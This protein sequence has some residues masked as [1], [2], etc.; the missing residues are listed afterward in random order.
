MGMKPLNEPRLQCK[1]CDKTFKKACKTI[2]HER[3]HTGERPFVCDY[4]DCDK[5]YRRSSHLLV[6][7]KAHKNIKDIICSY[8]GC[9]AS[10]RTKQHLHRHEISHV[11][12]TFKCDRPD[13]TAEFNKRNQLRWHK[14]AHLKDD[15]ECKTC[16]SKLDSLY[17]LEKHMER[18]HTNPVLH[19]CSYCGVEFQKWTELM[20]H[21]FEAHPPTCDI[22]NKVFSLKSNLKQHMAI[23]HTEIASVNCEFPGCDAVLRTKY[24]LKTHMGLKHQIG[25]SYT[26]VLC[27]KGFP[28]KSLYKKHIKKHD[29]EKKKEET[30]EEEEE[31]EAIEEEET[32]KEETEETEE[33]IGTA[34]VLTG[35]SSHQQYTKIYC[36]FELCSYTFTS[37][38]LL[39]RHLEGTVHSEEM[40]GTKT[41]SKEKCV[42]NKRARIA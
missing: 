19:K 33:K 35:R 4:P 28:F 26:C 42:I 39:R 17:A 40:K 13:C 14:A 9:G 3:T 6:H 12:A 20:A 38:Y 36:P 24:S 23:K 41:G 25:N 21:V 15:H 22:C 29:E 31:E 34:K 2:D 10:F 27:D 18:V 5:S 7:Q 37:K 16:G 11:D 30:E 32:K 8:K 1:F